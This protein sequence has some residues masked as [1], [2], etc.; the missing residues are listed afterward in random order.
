MG[1]CVCVC[2]CCG[3]CVCVGGGGWG[4]HRMSV[5]P[6]SMVTSSATSLHLCTAD[7]STPCPSSFGRSVRQ[8]RAVTL[9][10][11]LGGSAAPAALAAAS[12]PGA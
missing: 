11:R 9:S 2:V 10:A 5:S 6:G 12:E 3:V 4:A 1:W 8:A 7:P